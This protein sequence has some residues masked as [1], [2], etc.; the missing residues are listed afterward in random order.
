MPIFINGILEE[1]AAAAAIAEQFPVGLNSGGHNN[2]VLPFYV[3]NTGSPTRAVNVAFTGVNSCRIITY[4]RAESVWYHKVGVDGLDISV[5]FGF[6]SSNIAR[7]HGFAIESP[8]DA[9]NPV[10]FIE[11]HDVSQTPDTFAIVSI[12]VTD[13]STSMSP[14]TC[15]IAGANAPPNTNLMGTMSVPIASNKIMTF[16]QD[17]IYFGDITGDETG[18]TI[19][20]TDPKVTAFDVAVDVAAANVRKY[21]GYSIGTQVVLMRS[22]GPEVSG[23]WELTS[24][25]VLV[26][27]F[28]P[29]TIAG[30]SND[31]TD[32][33]VNHAHVIAQDGDFAMLSPVGA[34]TSNQNVHY[35]ISG[36]PLDD[37]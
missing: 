22:G 34:A 10:V 36:F 9:T 3:D 20:Y 28:D 27:A 24:A 15:T 35:T 30:L 6:N 19:T 13:G 23:M 8:A 31:L 7:M 1:A 17:D 29:F 21:T 32:S 4:T 33:L 12:E 18:F 2:Y 11:T 5:V 37:F 16:F 25:G 26:A 14:V